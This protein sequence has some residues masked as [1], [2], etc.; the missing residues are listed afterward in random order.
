MR[1]TAHT[2]SSS[3]RNQAVL[4]CFGS[5]KKATAPTKIAGNAKSELDPIPRYE[6]LLTGCPFKDEQV[7]PSVKMRLDL[8]NSIGNQSSECPGE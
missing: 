6:T 3:F 7:L 1:S 8:E 2:R 4:I 5:T